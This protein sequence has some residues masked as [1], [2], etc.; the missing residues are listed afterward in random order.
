MIRPFTAGM[1][2][3]ASMAAP[4][5]APIHTIDELHQL[6]CP[7]MATALAEQLGSPELDAL[8]F[9]ERLG[10][11]VDRELTERNSRQMTNRLRRAKLRHLACMED[12]DFRQPRGPD[13]DLDQPPSACGKA[14]DDV[15]THQ[16]LPVRERRFEHRGCGVGTD[17]LAGFLERLCDMAVVVCDAMTGGISPARHLADLVSGIDDRL[18]G[19]VRRG[20]EPARAG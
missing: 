1:I 17:D 16:H 2:S 9:E 15:G 19:T 11:L 13:K 10:L 4:M 14:L 6:R 7:G 20:R 12:I 3:R 18:K 8:S 5:H